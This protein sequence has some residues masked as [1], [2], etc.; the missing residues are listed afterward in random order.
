VN[1]ANDGAVKHPAKA[2]TKRRSEA[3]R[4]KLGSIDGSLSVTDSGVSTVDASLIS[5]QDHASQAHQACHV[6]PVNPPPKARKSSAALRAIGERANTLFKTT[7]KAL[8]RVSLDPSRI[9]DIVGGALV[10]LHFEHNR[11]T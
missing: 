1:T 10:L 5:P 8:R 9:N 2:S 7:F 6:G 4:V 11:T 3:G